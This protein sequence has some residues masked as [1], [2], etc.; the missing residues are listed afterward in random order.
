M[1]LGMLPHYYNEEAQLETLL[2]K[3][4]RKEKWTHEDFLDRCKTIE[5]LHAVRRV[6]KELENDPRRKDTG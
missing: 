4:D 1:M 2:G 3:L 6:I 5:R